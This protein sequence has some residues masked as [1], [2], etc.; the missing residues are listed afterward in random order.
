VEA[1]K[2]LAPDDAVRMFDQS[3]PSILACAVFNLHFEFVEAF[4]AFNLPRSVFGEDERGFSPMQLAAANGDK[5]MITLLV[6]RSGIL[7]T[8]GARSWPHPQAIHLAAASPASLDT[9]KTLVELG[10]N[11]KS[12]DGLGWTAID[13]AKA[14]SN[15]AT[16]EYLKEKGLRFKKE[17]PKWDRLLQVA[18]ARGD[19]EMVGW[20]T[21][22][23]ASRPEYEGHR[24][25]TPLFLAAKQGRLEVIKYLQEVGESFADTY[26]GKKL[27]HI[28]AEEGHIS[29]V[30]YLASQKSVNIN[31]RIYR[32]DWTPIC[33]AASRNQADVII[34]LVE[35]FGADVNVRSAGKHTALH[36]AA[37]HNALQAARQLIRC[38]V[39]VKA[40]NKDGTLA[41]DIARRNGYSELAKELKAAHHSWFT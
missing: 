1:L 6:P 36:I 25:G 34:V 4:L 21:E 32:E 28:A 16:L 37:Q 24:E 41:Y 22:A 26:Y 13:Y 14:R 9:I 19:V 3:G 35:E 12:E 10:A 2:N 38:G 11:I 27:L 23:A 17:D 31:A 20:L 5:D 29:V 40:W 39:K 18:G 8:G 7:L 15:S 33:S 30:R